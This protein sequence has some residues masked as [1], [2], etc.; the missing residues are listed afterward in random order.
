MRPRRLLFPILAFCAVAPAARAQLHVLSVSSVNVVGYVNTTLKPGFNLISNPLKAQ[1]NSIGALFQN[2]QGGLI[3]G[4]TVYKFENGSFSTVAW[5]DL[6]QQFGP[7]EA[8]LETTEPGD[9]IFVLLPGT[10]EKTITFVGDVPQGALSNPIPHGF[11]IK[12]SQVPQAITIDRVDFP[13]VPGDMLFL[14]NNDLNSYDIF[15]ASE[16]GG[17]LATSRTIKVGEA[18]WIYRAGPATQWTRIF[19]AIHPN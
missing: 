1:D 17:F 14:F 15:P 19:S 5:S 3:D 11:S 12:S 16:L 9:G 4:L 6:F 18:F 7:E 2:I 13:T 8:A 10:A